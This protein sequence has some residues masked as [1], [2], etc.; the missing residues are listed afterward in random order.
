MSHIGAIENVSSIIMLVKS[1]TRVGALNSD[2]EKMIQATLVGHF[3]LR[4]QAGGD[5]V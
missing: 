5:A 1:Q 2:P 4:T 3:K